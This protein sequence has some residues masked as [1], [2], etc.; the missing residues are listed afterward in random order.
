MKKFGVKK[1]AAIGIGAALVGTALAP[2]A[3]AAITLDKS[4]VY[5]S[6]G[7]PA[8]NIAVGS[9]AAIS[10]VVW[11]GNIAA[12]LAQKAVSSSSAGAGV[13]DVSNAQVELVLGGTATYSS[14]AKEY[15]INLNSSSGT[16]AKELDD[17]TLTNAQLSNLKE[18]TLTPKVAGATSTITAKEKI[19]LDVDAKFSRVS[20]IK[21]LIAEIGS[22]EFRYQVDLG[23]GITLD[24]KSNG[25]SNT[26]FSDSGSSDNVRVPFFGD[27]YQLDLADFNSSTTN[28]KLVKTSAKQRFDEGEFITGLVGRGSLDGQTVSVK[29]ASV[30]Q[31][32]GTGTYTASW[33]IYDEEGNK[34][35][36]QTASSGNLN[37]LFVDSSGDYVLR[38]N[39]SIEG[40]YL[41][42]TTNIGYGEVT[43]GTDT[44]ELYNTKGYPYDATDTSGIYDYTVTLTAS[45]GKFTT[46]QIQ[47]SR[48]TW[49]TTT[50]PLY[51]SGTGQSL[52]GHDA[53]TATFGEV[54]LAGTAGKGIAE[55]DF[56]GFEDDESKTTIVLGKRSGDESS[57]SVDSRAI[58]KAEFRDGSDNLHRI[59]LALKLS[60]NTSGDT[61]VYDGKTYWYKVNVGTSQSGTYDTNFQV[62]TGVGVDNNYVN[63]VLWDINGVVAGTGAVVTINGVTVADW[64]IDE[65]VTVHGTTYKLMTALA[66]KVLT[67]AVDSNMQV[68]LSNSTG[69][70][71]DHNSIYLTNN[72]VWDANNASRIQ[73][74]NLNLYGSPGTTWKQRYAIRADES[75][76]TVWLLL[77]GDQNLSS[78]TLQYGEYATF[79]DT[80]ENEGTAVTYFSPD[81]PEYAGRTAG[82]DQYYIANFI[83]DD[84]L[85]AVNPDF[86]VLLDASD[87][88]LLGPF[89]NTNLTGFTFDANV[90]VSQTLD[91]TLQSGTQTNYI[92]AGFTDVAGKIVLDETA[93]TVTIKM[94]QNLEQIVINVL[95]TGAVQEISG[96]TLTVA[97]G[98]TGESSGGTKI[99]VNDITGVEVVGAESG[100][101]ISVP[102]PDNGKGKV[103]TAA[104]APSGPNIL[105]GGPVVNQLTARVSGIAEQLQAEGDTADI[106]ADASGN[107]VVAG[108]SAANTGT[109]AQEFIDWLDSL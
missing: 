80:R 71:I 36:S 64:N 56:K 26:Y 103:Y 75:N 62:G 79:V 29:L 3:S 53:V 106:E 76:N 51:P 93:E 22:G 39:L 20:S 99:T 54:L 104:D 33:E 38:S 61:F 25:T 34:I 57:P 24:E 102:A 86:N 82:D 66:T 48:E 47:N 45:A 21:D 40:V 28:V 88:G 31:T 91:Y 85:T 50:T 94:P 9:S 60:W 67:V 105:V 84:D 63:G 68:R 46:I 70:V 98:D 35:D 108:Y 89:P 23:T 44:V 37:E 96:E 78:S 16:A 97:Y 11:A 12:K 2:M 109:A 15:K 30:S 52:T 81:V 77:D 13:A 101:A 90:F 72:T 58:G 42:T 18:E 4:D 74:R 14:G 55:I 32:S 6:A 41:A 100:E 87:G 10:D 65:T 83:I 5:T 59:P 92:K 95:G 27:T 43:V 19:I 69:D 1:L 49:T 73:N 17:N 8:V 7:S 107:I